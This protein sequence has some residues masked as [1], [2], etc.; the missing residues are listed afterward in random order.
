M[1]IEVEA[2]TRDGHTASVADVERAAARVARR[3]VV[4]QETRQ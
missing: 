2:A 3:L 1:N 4:S